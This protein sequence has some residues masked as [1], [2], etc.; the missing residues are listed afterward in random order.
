VIVIDASA[1][2]NGLVGPGA[3]RDL[4]LYEDLHAPD[5]IDLELLSAFRGAVIRGT[6]ARDTA[7]FLFNRWTAVGIRR[8]PTRG[9]LPRAWALMTNIT[10]YDGVYVALA[11]TLRCPLRPGRRPARAFGRAGLSYHPRLMTQ[12]TR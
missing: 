1:A 5:H 6:V 3:A 2:M 4:M 11:E 9:F 12:I 10:P 7:E 8:Y